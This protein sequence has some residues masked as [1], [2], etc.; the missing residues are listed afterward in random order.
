MIIYKPKE[1]TKAVITIFTDLD[2][3]YC[4]KLHAEIPKL[5]DMGIEVRYLAF[6]RQGVGSPAYDTLVAIWCARD[7]SEA[8]TQAMHGQSPGIMTCA[9]PVENHMRLGQKAGIA[10]TPTIIFADG[11]MS[12]GYSSASRLAR[13]AIK[14][15]GN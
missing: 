1:E 2:C 6:P 3:S 10:G 8:M 11:T 15:K 5:V 7:R 13:D 9:N 14:H 12:P 4:R